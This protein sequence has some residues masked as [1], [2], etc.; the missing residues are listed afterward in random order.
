MSN[1]INETINET[2]QEDEPVVVTHSKTTFSISKDATGD[3]TSVS[4]ETVDTPESYSDDSDS[5]DNISRL[6]QPLSLTENSD[7]YIVSIDG[8]PK[9]YVKDKTTAHEKMW[10]VARKLSSTQFFAGYNTNFLS[11]RENELHLLGSYRFFLIAYDTILHRIS[12]SHVQEC[13]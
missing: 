1:T 6:L 7:L 10:E 9:F 12:Y 3:N 8:Q 4:E 5:E 13:T 11:I 2:I